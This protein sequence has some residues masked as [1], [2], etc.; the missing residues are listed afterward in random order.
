MNEIITRRDQQVTRQY[1]ANS[2]FSFV[3]QFSNS[4]GTNIEKLFGGRI[5]MA[6]YNIS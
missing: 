1:G 3:S 2:N 4:T 6:L 5:N